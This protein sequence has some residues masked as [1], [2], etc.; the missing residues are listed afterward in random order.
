VVD[1]LAAARI[2][3]R[4]G[5]TLVSPAVLDQLSR[6]V[7]RLL[8]DHH[9]AEPL[10]EGLPREEVRERAFGRAG[11]GVFERVVAD[12]EASGKVTGRDRLALSSHRVALSGEEERARAA[13]DAALREAGLKPPDMSSLASECGLSPAVVDRVT[14]LLLRQKTLVKLDTLLFHAQALD[15]LKREMAAMKATVGGGPAKIDVATFKERYGVSRKFA[16]PLLEYLDRERI[17]RRVGDAR[18]LI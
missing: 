10:S 6:D 4:A 5:S 7:L 13:I 9:R 2:A 3:S 11:E 8:G 15:Q 14:H 12:L 16:I 18:V 1:R 17:T